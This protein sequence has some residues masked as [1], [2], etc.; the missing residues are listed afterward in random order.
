MRASLDTNIL[1][2]LYNANLQSILFEIFDEGV[3]IY[4]MIRSV[5][6]EKHG[7]QLLDKIDEDIQAEKIKVYTDTELK[8]KKIY[9]MFEIN[10]NE[11]K[12]LYGSGDLGEI[13]AISLAQTLGAYFLLTDD[14]KNG[15]PYTSLLQFDCDVMPFNFADVLILRY[16]TKLADEKQTIDDFDT[17]NNCSSL[18]WSLKSK[19]NR[20]SERFHGKYK[21]EDKEW[22]QSLE[23]K[24][25]INVE[26]KLTILKKKI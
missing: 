15:G 11:N 6:L 18:N 21:K 20:F 9:S 26:N 8:D 3:F 13:Y 2:H 17:V 1:I 25:K 24:Y 19:I 23:D 4:E 7:K 22:I 14:T 5:E 12:N 16:L 10:V